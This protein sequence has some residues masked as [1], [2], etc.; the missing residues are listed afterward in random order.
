MYIGAGQSHTISNQVINE[1]IRNDGNLT[2]TNCT[3]NGEISGNG[4]LT[5]K[6][7]CTLNGNVHQ[8]NICFG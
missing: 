6:G 4:N 1:A 3:V 7:N 8:N 5:T 2:L